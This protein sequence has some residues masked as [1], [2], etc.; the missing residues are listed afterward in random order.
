MYCKIEQIKSL[1]SDIHKVSIM[2]ITKKRK[3][4]NICKSIIND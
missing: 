1:G 4:K 2:E 3:Y